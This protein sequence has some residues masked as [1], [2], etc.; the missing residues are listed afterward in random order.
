MRR[1]IVFVLIIMLLLTCTSVFASTEID[2]FIN[3]YN[4]N[5]YMTLAI[6]GAQQD[7][8]EAAKATYRV[9]YD[10]QKSDIFGHPVYSTE[11]TLYSIGF[12][13]NEG[14]DPLSG[15]WFGVPSQDNELVTLL[16]KP[17]LYEYFAAYQEMG[18]YGIGNIINWVNE[19]HSDFPQTIFDEFMAIYETNENTTIIAFSKIQD[20][21]SQEDKTMS[22]DPQK[23]VP[24]QGEK[25]ALASAKSYLT[26]SAFSRQGLIDQLKYEGYLQGEAEYAV[27][28]CGAD[29]YEQAAKSAK[30]YLEVSSFSRASLIEQLEYEG[31]THEQAIYGVEQNGY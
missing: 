24:T 9:K 27:D 18:I 8:I 15:F 14:N 3:E 7:K 23:N 20:Q 22:N 4:N 11:E 28:N 30:T 31:F 10:R 26:F 21:S 6:S 13:S 5:L 17:F 1:I 25:N 16:I 19:G 2:D 29:W 12:N